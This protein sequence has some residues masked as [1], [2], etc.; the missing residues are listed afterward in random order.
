MRTKG[1][2]ETTLGAAGLSGVA[3]ERVPVLGPLGSHF[4]AADAPRAA[5]TISTAAPG[6][7]A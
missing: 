5:S 2:V 3:W 1:E 6:R 4:V 7:P